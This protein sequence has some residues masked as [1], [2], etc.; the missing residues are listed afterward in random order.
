MDVVVTGGCGF[1]GSELVRHWIGTGR[2]RVDNVDSLT[3]A[4]S[5]ARVASVADDPAYRFHRLDVADAG[6]IAEL[7][8][9][10][11]PD[12]VVHFAAESHVT[13]SESDPDTFWRTNVDGTR[14]LLDAARAAG[15]PRFLHVSTDEVYGSTTGRAFRETDKL[16]GTS[17]ATSPYSRSKSEADDLARAAGDARMRVVVVRPTNCFGPWQY[18]EKALPRWITR[19]LRG[20]PLPVWGD[21]LYVRQWLFVSDLVVALEMLLTGDPEHD[22]YNVGPRHEPEITN[23]AVA[24]WLVDH[25]GLSPDL[26]VHTPYDRPDHDRRY[27]VDPARIEGLGWRGGDV[28]E[29]MAETVAWYRS[30]EAW[31]APLLPDAESIYDDEVDA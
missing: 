5:P 21:G 18:P 29:Q 22:V 15:V 12:A 24:R 9:D 4:G 19:A 14:A 8:A 2:G 28:W 6:A 16:A 27:A 17:Q 31:W 11:R 1:I 20:R 7:V 25:L 23:V 30:N 13:R 26:V 10:V 3:Y